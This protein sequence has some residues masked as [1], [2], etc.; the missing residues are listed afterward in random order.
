VNLFSYPGSNFDLPV[1]VYGRTLS[2]LVIGDLDTLLDDAEFHKDDHHCASDEEDRLSR[3]KS[4][5]PLSR[6]D[7]SDNLKATTVNMKC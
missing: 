6:F 1:Q 2:A 3:R 5:R 7:F 4:P